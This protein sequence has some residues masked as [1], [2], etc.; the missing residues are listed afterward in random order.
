[1]TSPAS[2]KIPPG[3]VHHL[4]DEPLADGSYVLYWMQQSQRAEVNHALEYAVRRANP[5]G[6]PVVVAFGLTDGYPDAN[7]RHYRFMLEGLA[8]T[9]EAVERRGAAFVLRRGEPDDVALAL[10]ADASLVVCDRGYLRHQRAWRERVAAEA[11]RA[12]VEVE[13]D[14]VVP[15]EV[16]SDKREWAAWTLRPKIHRHL[17]EYLVELATTPIENRDTPAIGGLDPSDPDAI[18]EDL[19]V[20]RSVAPVSRHFE[21]G[22]ARARARLA[23]FLEES[24][25]LYEERGSA[26]HDD[27]ASRLSPYLHFGQISPLHVALE[28]RRA[29]LGRGK[30]CRDHAEAFLEQLVVRRELAFNHCWYARDEYDAWR[31]LPDWARETLAEHAGDP[32]GSVYTRSE[33][34]NGETDDPY[35][36]AAMREMRETGWLHNHM[37]MYWG[38]RIVGWT[39]TPE[40]AY[41]VAKELN[42]RW[43]VDGRDPASYANVGWLFGLHDR[44]WPERE[45]YGKVRIMTRSGLERK[46]DPEAYVKRVERLVNRS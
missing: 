15:V 34:E 33:M 42:D 43:F 41:R 16:A 17:D 30:P 27:A 20:D 23:R 35:W 37:R 5:R 40:H 36:N 31:G 11:G 39:N 46:T 18:M 29:A 44:P 14:A 22:T 38:K 7:L 2:P 12:V 45:V 13:A 1:M 28:T 4:N 9:A 6:E 32:R 19:D 10:A 25:A 24:L 21:G 3:R 8:A 26:P